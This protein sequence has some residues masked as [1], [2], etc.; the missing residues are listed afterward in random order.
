M[1]TMPRISRR[2]LSA[3]LLSVAGGCTQTPA[4]PPAPA[5]SATAAMDLE[6]RCVAAPRPEGSVVVRHDCAGRG[7]LSRAVRFSVDLPAG[8]EFS[9]H[10][11]RDVILMASRGTAIITLH[12]GDQIPDPVTAADSADYWRMAAEVLLDRAPTAAEADAFRREARDAGGAR[13]RL[14]RAQLADSALLRLAGHL[15][16]Q[17]AGTVLHQEREL[18]TWAGGPAGYLYEVTDRDEGRVSSGGYVTVRDGVFYGIAFMIRE[19]DFETH[20]ARW[21][22]TAAS[23][24]IHP[25]Q[26]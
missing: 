18:R 14:T 16:S 23:V 15:T 26:P 17:R 7:E 25:R 19:A 1:H 3:V 10:I 4:P 9:E 21:E 24:V 2:A 20:R 12:G 13:R 8:W 5:P 11:Q 22:R 6:P